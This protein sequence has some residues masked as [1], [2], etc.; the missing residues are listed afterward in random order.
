MPLTE[1]GTYP[2]LPG[3]EQSKFEPEENKSERVFS[4][5]VQCRKLG[6]FFL[7]FYTSYSRAFFI[8]IL[9]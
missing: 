3:E 4:I 5:L 2:Q 7:H 6:G 1:S 8:L 9:I